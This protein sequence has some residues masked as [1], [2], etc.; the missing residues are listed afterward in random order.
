[1]EKRKVA[2]AG[3][4]T[5]QTNAK[6]FCSD[7]VAMHLKWKSCIMEVSSNHCATFFG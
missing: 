1:M 4:T 6:V 2:T 5:T 3:T 7:N